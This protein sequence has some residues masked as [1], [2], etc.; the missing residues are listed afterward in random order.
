MGYVW[1]EGVGGGT[2]AFSAYHVTWP[3]TDKFAGTVLER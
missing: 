2:V 1:G 3:F